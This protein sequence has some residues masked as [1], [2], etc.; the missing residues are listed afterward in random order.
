MQGCDQLGQSYVLKARPN[1]TLLCGP[2]IKIVKESVTE[3]FKRNHL[4]EFDLDNT[5]YRK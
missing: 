5:Y 1:G 4:P 2:P 3:I